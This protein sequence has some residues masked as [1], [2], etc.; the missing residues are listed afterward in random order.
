MPVPTKSSR[1][2]LRRFRIGTRLRLVFTAIVL[3]M[4]L[5]ASVALFFQQSTRQ[6]VEQVAAA[7]RRMSAVLHVDNGV[8]SLMNGLH[9]SADLRDAERFTR[10]AQRLLTSFHSGTDSAAALLRAVPADNNRQ[11]AIVDSLNG[12]LEALPHRAEELVALGRADDWTAVHARLLNQ[13]DRTD[14]VVNALVAELSGDLVESRARLLAQ[15]TRAELR[16]GAVLGGTLLAG[17]MLATLLGLAVTRSITKPLSQLDAGTRALALG[18]FGRQ[19]EASGTDELAQLAAAFNQ[20][21]VQLESLYGKL[22]LSEA[23]FRSLIE[24]AAEMILIVSQAGRILYASP[25]TVRIL[26]QPPEEIVGRPIEKLFADTD[27]GAGRRTLAEIA[28]REGASEPFELYFRHQDGTSRAIEGVVT[29]L[30]DATVGGIVINARDI[31]DRRRA[32]A[33]LRESEE[34]LRQA[35][36]MEAIGRV[37]GGVAH[38]F[39]N[40][41]TVINGYSEMLLTSIDIADPRRGHVQDVRDA[42]EQATRLT[43]QLLAFSRK[44]MLHP[45]VLDINDVVRETERMLR[46][47]IP[48]DIELISTLR[49]GLGAVE[50]DRTQLQQV[51]INLAVNARDAMPQGGRLTIETAAADSA[52]TVAV[53]DTGAGMDEATRLRVFEP[54][55]TTKSIGKGTGLG[56]STV[57]G[58]VSQSGGT[59][60]VQSDVGKGTTFRISL[61]RS[62]RQPEIAHHVSAAPAVWGHE[63]ILVVEDQPEV[64]AFACLSLRQFGY[65]V[66]E[67]ADGEEALCLASGRA[68]IDLLLTDVVMPGMDGV[69]LSKRLLSLRPSVKVI[70]TSGYADSMLLHHGVT[71]TGAALIPKPYGAT[72]LATRI[73]EVLEA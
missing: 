53:S 39:N 30:L 8:L 20:M 48:E 57:Y 40:L 5:G 35:Q 60:S 63:T 49:P 26:G 62:E 47:V 12:L 29:N 59:I 22:L 23:R 45:A 10:D 15:V 33:A 16:A 38:D 37:A 14:D 43:Q 31:S 70:F 27:A 44:Q 55:F 50:A 41:L 42:G 19:I 52:V 32:E 61:P 46:R 64:R 9:R 56:L 24:N 65:N 13:V 66:L 67:A 21:A 69:E 4:L 36:K 6:Q 18:E 17:L 25:S 58:I 7:E 1:A 72:A 3:L 73:R 68:S 28:R 2:V 11:A 54:F 51:L 71:D 34:Q